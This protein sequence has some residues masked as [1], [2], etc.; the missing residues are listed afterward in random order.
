M[1]TVGHWLTRYLKSRDIDALF[2]L[3]GG[4]ILPLRDGTASPLPRD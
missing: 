1:D 2:T 3:T 4:H